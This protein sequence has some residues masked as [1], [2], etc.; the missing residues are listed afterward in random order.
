MKGAKAYQE[1]SVS[2]F[3]SPDETIVVGCVYDGHGGINGRVASTCCVNLTREFFF[4]HFDEVIKWSD[5]DWRDRMNQFFEQMHD[6]VRA[7]FIKLEQARRVLSGQPTDNI[8]DS[9]KIVRK[10]TGFPVHGGTTGTICI[11]INLNDR[12]RA[13]CANVGDSDCILLPAQPKDRHSKYKHLSV[14]HGPDSIDEF[15][16]IKAL[17]LKTS[18]I[19]VYDK[20][21]LKKHECPRVFDANGVKNPQYVKDPWGMGLRPTNVRYDPG[22]YAVTPK[23]IGEDTTCIAMTRSIG[24]LYAHQFGMTKLPSI[25]FEELDL[26]EEYVIAVGSDGVWDCWKWADFADF[27]NGCL[28]KYDLH[29]G[30]EA[31]IQHTIARAKACFG[32][33]SFDDASLAVLQLKPCR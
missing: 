23:G 1:D 7:E 16:R 17:N 18:L 2:V 10:H 20:Q 15:S 9:S 3:W 26:E 22:V 27:L 25:T 12:R 30:T 6:S 11:V 13:I 14:D 21:G 24:D 29:N 8:V 28:A 19:F 5:Q 32:T 33:K 31:I 4:Q